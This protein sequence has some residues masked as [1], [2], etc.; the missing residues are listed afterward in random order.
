MQTAYRHRFTPI[1]PA[2]V[3]LMILAALIFESCTL[4]DEGPHMKFG[5]TVSDL[6]VIHSD[7]TGDRVLAVG[8]DFDGLYL[9]DSTFIVHK[10]MAEICR[11]S[12]TGTTLT[13]LYP[14][15]QWMDCSMSTDRTRI[16]LTTYKSTPSNEIYLMNA[17]GTNLIRCSAS[18]GLY[19]RARISPDVDEILF[20]QHTRVGTMGVDGGNPLMIDSS[21]APVY[22]RDPLYVDENRILY[23]VD[24]G[25]TSL[26]LYNKLNHVRTL[27]AANHSFVYGQHA[28]RG[29]TLLC[30][31]LG[32][33][34]LVD[35]RTNMVTTL[36]PGIWA[37]FSPDG[38]K[39]VYADTWHV[40]VRDFQ[41][42]SSLAV[43]SDTDTQ[44]WISQP[45]MSPD[46]RFIVFYVNS[47]VVG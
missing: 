10:W 12:Y 45:E 7:G 35:L 24:S 8:G 29:D 13:Q 41:S 16:V 20:D 6:H 4:G 11:A 42:G 25:S 27:I 9:G 21:K 22:L 3:T 26:V 17:T 36:S 39:I 34:K 1:P 30:V 44:K 18:T 15:I 14:D 23:S 5:T 37:S 31:E 32:M 28:V 46:N 43:Y 2:L 40:Y 19:V 33:V 38:S 47:N